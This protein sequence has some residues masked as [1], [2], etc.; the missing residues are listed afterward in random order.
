M[1]HFKDIGA[2]DR[3]LTIRKKTDSG[4]DIYGHPTIES[5][6]DTDV[7]AAYSYAGKDE[8]EEYGKQSEYQFLHF[9]IRYF[10]GL[11]LSDRVIYEDDIYEIVKI[12][13]IGRKRYFKLKVKRL[14]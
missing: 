11:T 3:I 8:S 9:I 5:T 10:D 7:N 1:R 2:L 13:P 4:S 12:E 14:N 6:V